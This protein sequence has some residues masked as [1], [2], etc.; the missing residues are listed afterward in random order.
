[1]S[2]G[3]AAASATM[4]P[5][6]PHRTARHGPRGDVARPDATR[7]LGGE[8]MRTENTT[9]PA[10]MV[11]RSGPRSIGSG[12]RSRP[13][14]RSSAGPFALGAV[15]V[16][17]V[18]A[19]LASPLP[20]GERIPPVGPVRSRPTTSSRS[21]APWKRSTWPTG[22]IRGD[23]SR[24]PATGSTRRTD[25]SWPS[26]TS[27]RSRSTQIRKWA[28]ELSPWDSSLG[29]QEKQDRGR[30]Q[31]LESY[32]RKLD[33][34]VSAH[35]RIN[36]TKSRAAGSGPTRRRR[37]SSRSRPRRTASSGW[38]PSSRCGTSSRGSSPT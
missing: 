4:T 27:A 17:I 13:S 16:V 22:S 3:A 34:I 1:M 36:R 32:I 26:S 21:P 30:E 37:A 35:V 29:V 2:L 33:G 24:S 8:P 7:S 38:R 5:S 15:V 31:E 20:S 9:F 25:M 6:G 11:A 10:A 18:L 14:G 12:A 23:E 19:Y 28:G